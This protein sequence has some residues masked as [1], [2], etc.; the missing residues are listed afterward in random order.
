M[1]LKTNVE[2]EAVRVIK[3]LPQMLAGEQSGKKVAVKYA[4]PI[5]LSVD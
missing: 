2:E 1:N 5:T 4:L 3:S